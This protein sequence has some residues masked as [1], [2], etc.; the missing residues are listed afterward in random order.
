MP[1]ESKDFETCDKFIRGHVKRTMVSPKIFKL[2][3]VPKL[4]ATLSDT[5]ESL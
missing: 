1:M 2:T 4:L 5:T 3:K